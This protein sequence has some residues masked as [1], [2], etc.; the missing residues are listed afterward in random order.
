MT[1]LA[2]AEWQGASGK[3]LIAAV[4]AAYEVSARV[5]LS[6]P[7]LLKV[8]SPPPDLKL[9]WWDPFGNNYSVFGTT[10]GSAKL[11]HLDSKQTANAMGIAGYT[12][13]VNTFRPSSLRA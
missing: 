1:P 3:D 8:V 11:L 9:D 4:V 5:G 6:M 10:V 12:A 7:A 13:P 2:V